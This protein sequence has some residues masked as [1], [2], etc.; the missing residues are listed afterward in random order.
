MRQILDRI[1][2]VFFTVMAVVLI[3]ISI[4]CQDK[5]GDV[6]Q[7]FKKNQEGLNALQKDPAQAVKFFR[8]AQALDPKNPDFTNNVGVAFLTMGK[9]Q[10]A[11]PYFVRATELDS[12]YV[13]GFYNEGVCYQNLQK[14]EEAVR[15][16]KKAL[17]LTEV[18]EIHFNLGI[19]YTRL[20]DKKKAIEHYQ[21]FITVAPAGMEQPV[22]DAKEKIKILSQ[23]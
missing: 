22:S 9:C 4:N 3:P 15:A 14:N 2:I 10:E 16:Y 18:P 8:E 13:R 21:K 1:K 12:K 5:G 19:V 6:N 11:I 20:N 7:A 23:N 17:N